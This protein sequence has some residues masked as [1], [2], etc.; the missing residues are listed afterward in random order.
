MIACKHCTAV[1]FKLRRANIDQKSK[2][3]ITAHHI[4]DNIMQMCGDELIWLYLS[5][6]ALDNCMME[7]YGLERPHYGYHCL[8]KVELT[9]DIGRRKWFELDFRFMKLTDRLLLRQSQSGWI[10]PRPRSWT[11]CLR[12]SPAPTSH[13]AS[14]ASST[15]PEGISR[16]CETAWCHCSPIVLIESWTL[17]W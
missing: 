3:F 7:N 4:C 5:Q 1:Y 15:R 2:P 14:L 17:L 12:T 6:A 11:H 9:L 13:G 16:Y 8:P 10:T